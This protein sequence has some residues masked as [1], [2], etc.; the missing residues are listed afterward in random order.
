MMAF[1]RGFALTGEL[2][3]LLNDSEVA[4]LLGYRDAA[5]FRRHRKRLEAAGFPKRGRL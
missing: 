3:R 4:A 1:S 2:L 5:A